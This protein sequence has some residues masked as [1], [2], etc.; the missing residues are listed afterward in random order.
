MTAPPITPV[1]CK[2]ARRLVGWN[3]L[4]LARTAATEPLE[5]SRFEGRH[6]MLSLGKLAAVQR[7]FEAAGVEFTH[8]TP[9]LRGA[10]R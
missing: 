2:A 1:Q 4:D 5:L 3:V 6:G 7:A 8:G 10:P 9:H